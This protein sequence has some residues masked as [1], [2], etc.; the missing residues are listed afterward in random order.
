MCV[1]SPSAKP[2]LLVLGYGNPGRGDDGLGPHLLTLLQGCAQDFKA[3]Q[4]EF[5]VDFQ[6]QIEHVLDLQAHHLALFIDAQYPSAMPGGVG[7][8]RVV[9]AK[10]DSTSTHQLSPAA[11]LTVYQHALHHPA[12]PA[13]LLT[14]Q[15]QTFELGQTLSQPAR[16]HLVR[17]FAL[18]YYLLQMP[19]LAVWQACAR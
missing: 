5:I 15:G 18:G 14:I 3:A 2:K 1:A 13:F 7:F 8:K 6:L 19:D 16:R 9:A 12:P 17:A 11:L 4:L 10:D